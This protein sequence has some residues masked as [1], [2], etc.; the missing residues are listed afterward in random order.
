MSS[1]DRR[2][3]GRTSSLS[4][5]NKTKVDMPNKFAD[6]DGSPG[7]IPRNLNL[8]SRKKKS[9]KQS[10]PEDR[11]ISEHIANVSDG[12]YDRQGQSPVSKKKKFKIAAQEP[13]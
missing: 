6:M 3:D 13:I 12:S 4:K 11:E 10:E 5:K 7:G 8:K 9:I 2:G 1:F